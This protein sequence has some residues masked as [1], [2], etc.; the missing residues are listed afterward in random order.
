MIAAGNLDRRI[1]VR[2]LAEGRDALNAPSTD[3]ADAATLW[4]SYRPATA[5]ER[6]AA[7]ELGAEIDA[8]FRVR[9]STF[10]ST[11]TSA[12]SI[13]FDGRDFGIVGAVEVDRR[14]GVEISAVSR[15]DV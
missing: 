6:L 5:R 12:D 8:V 11:I 13:A 3:W 4:A 9:W 10:A 2:R 7:G 14:V 1:T 15:G